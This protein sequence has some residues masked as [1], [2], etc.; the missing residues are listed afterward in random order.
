MANPL[1][2]SILVFASLFI[3]FK[4][5][6]CQSAF[7]MTKWDKNWHWG[8]CQLM[9]DIREWPLLVNLYWSQK[10]PGK[11][12]F[13]GLYRAGIPL[14]C[15]LL[16]GQT[17]ESNQTNKWLCSSSHTVHDDCRS[18]Y[19]RKTSERRD[20]TER[21]LMRRRKH[22]RKLMRDCNLNW[23]NS[24]LRYESKESSHCQ[25]MCILFLFLTF[26]TTQGFLASIN[27]HWILYEVTTWD[28]IILK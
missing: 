20:L 26:H 19:T 8:L 27:W 21:G 4:T 16:L 22:Y 5:D 18:K 9:C 3:I 14:E 6:I 2:R 17:L 13:G 24:A 15:T 25:H 11:P 28:E 23:A 1:K 12:L 10:R 7:E